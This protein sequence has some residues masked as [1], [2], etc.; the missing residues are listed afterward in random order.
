MGYLV[1][2]ILQQQMKLFVEIEM[3]Y[4]EAKAKEIK[5]VGLEM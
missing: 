2:Q 4:A 1:V 3:E 5:N